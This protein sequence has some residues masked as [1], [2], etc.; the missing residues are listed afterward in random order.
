MR[1]VV[2]GCRGSLAAPGPETVAYGGNTSCVQLEL[3][4]G[5][6]LVLDAGTGIRL[7]GLELARRPR[8]PIH[9]VLTHLHLDHLEGLG[10]FVPLW[11]PGLE[12]HIW[13]PA[14]PVDS[15]DERIT[16]YLS[17]PLFPVQLSEVPS[18]VTFHDLPDETFTIGSAR[19]LAEPV[20]H[21]GPTVGLRIEEPGGRTLT[22]IP[23]HEPYLGAGPAGVDPEWL[24]GFT[25]ADGAHVLMH[26]AQYFEHEYPNHVGWGHSSVEH[27]VTFA[28]ASRVE[29]LVLFHHDPM[30]S[31]DQLR[32]LQ[33]RARALWGPNGHPPEL[34]H[35]GMTLSFLAE[36]EA[37]SQSA[38][39]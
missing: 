34:A 32:S 15:L 13:G 20:S 33:A 18:N 14:S 9:V 19:I 1:A 28:Q 23:D 6:P 26:D 31:D 17:P 16:K 5:T 7:L 11:E 29:R 3:T 30:H 8:R 10:F 38:S 39:R 2:W 24:S 37:S 25:L 35:E 27:A 36:V 21:R 12:L 4:D 22:Y